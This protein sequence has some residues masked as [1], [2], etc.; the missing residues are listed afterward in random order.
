M[1]RAIGDDLDFPCGEERALAFYR[2][3]Q[4]LNHLW[5]DAYAARRGAEISGRK[6]EVK[7]LDREMQVFE[8]GAQL[9]AEEHDRLV[10]ADAWWS[11][12]GARRRTAELL[13]KRGLATF[14]AKELGTHVAQ[15]IVA[16]LDRQAEVARL[17]T[18]ILLEQLKLPKQQAAGAEAFHGE[19]KA[20]AAPK[21]PA[22]VPAPAAKP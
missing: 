18:G 1:V 10:G 11:R 4:A 19:L 14:H 22:A 2:A 6:D 5:G 13:E 17:Q 9:L 3:S 15:P 12:R 8:R 21:A 16:A 20:D 7:A